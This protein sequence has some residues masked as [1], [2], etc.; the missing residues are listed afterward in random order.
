MSRPSSLRKS[1]LAPDHLKLIKYGS[2]DN[3]KS[4]DDFKTE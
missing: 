3:V 2:I 4:N 1:I